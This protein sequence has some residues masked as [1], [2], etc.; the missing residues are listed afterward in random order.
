VQ[1]IFAG[2][3]SATGD[4]R[5]VNDPQN[6]AMPRFSSSKPRLATQ[7]GPSALCDTVC[8]R[9]RAPTPAPGRPRRGRSR[10]RWQPPRAPPA[11]A[12]CPP[13][14]TPPVQGRVRVSG[15]AQCHGFGAEAC[16]D[17]DG[18]GPA[19]AKAALCAGRLKASRRHRR[20]QAAAEQK[21]AS[22]LPSD[23]GRVCG[24]SSGQARSS[25]P[26]AHMLD[27][28]SPFPRGTAEH[29][30]ARDAAGEH[31]SKPGRRTDT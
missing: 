31:Q 22:Q 7:G 24:T 2:L 6:W 13:A 26:P 3:S 1:G 18:A 15:C 4:E 14:P 20:T 16:A 23:A 10:R 8:S 11:R 30:H 28:G 21:A 25:C 9:P 17:S 5:A 27:A 29:M 12:P 19:S